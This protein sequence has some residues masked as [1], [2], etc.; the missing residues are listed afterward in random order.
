MSLE[1]FEEGDYVTMKELWTYVQA[2]ASANGYAVVKRRFKIDSKTNALKKIYIICDLSRTPRPR[3]DAVRRRKTVS[4]KCDCFFKVTV[5]YMKAKNVWTLSIT[6]GDHNHDE[7]RLSASA[8]NRKHYT[9]ITNFEV[10]VEHASRTD[11]TSAQILTQER[12]DHS[13][14][15]LI[16]QDIYNIRKRIRRRKLNKYTSTQALLLKLHREK[17]FVRVQLNEKIKRVKRLFFVN[18]GILRNLLI[19]NYEILIMNA[20]YKIN[21]YKISL[22]VIVDETTLNIIF[23][24]V[25]AFL[26]D[27]TKKNFIWVIEQIKIL[28]ASLDLFDSIVIVTNRNLSL[29]IAIKKQYSIIKNL[30][31]VWHV[32]KNVIVNCR[33]SFD[34]ENEWNDF[35]ESYLKIMYAHTKDEYRVAYRAFFEQ[36]KSTHEADVLYIRDIWI[37]S[38]LKKIVR[39]YINRWL[40]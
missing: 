6:H 32:N 34:N 10:T 36:W 3:A 33:A 30:L 7:Y 25:F 24:V 26:S 23:Y 38:H 40:L 17:W 21:R 9:V 12:L 27:E 28:Y 29:M 35:Y 11:L 20:I 15:L 5:I 16:A 37:A 8:A 2:T 22:L 14:T 1:P 31:C 18:K 39:A 4:I 13:D 19:K